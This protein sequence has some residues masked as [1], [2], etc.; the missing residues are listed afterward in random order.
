MA[1]DADPDK[2]ECPPHTRAKHQILASYL[3]AWYPILST[4]N[5]RIAFLD[6]FAGR[7]RYNDGSEGSPLIALRHLLDHRAWPSMQH[8]EFVFLF[9]EANADNSATLEAEVDRFKTARAPWP[10]NVRVHVINAPFD[11]TATALLDNL[12]VQKRKLAPTFAFVDPFGY[13]GLPMSL[14]AELLSFPKTELFVN[15]MVGHVQRFIERDGQE[16]AMRDLFGLHVEDILKDWD[17]SDVGRVEHLRAVYERQL[18]DVVGFP[19]VQSFGMVN[20]TGNLGYYLMHG[21]RHPSAVKAMKAAMW[22]IDPAGGFSFSDR[23]AGENVLFT[24][25]PDLRPLRAAIVAGFAGKAG[26]SIDDIE[27]FAILKT[28]YRETH[29]R[30]A[31]AP[32]EGD[33]VIVVH[34]PGKRGFP[35]GTTID[36]G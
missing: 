14:I 11:K 13:R 35:S 8:K 25:E 26:V 3:D 21:T 16:R 34:R 9:V 5:G 27:W 20:S 19:Y 15:F 31:I 24:P 23:L 2:W 4:W 7:G 33:G 30:K 36:F 6:G 1:S 17:S 10:P 29:V 18:T 12:R 32:L 22:S 28:P